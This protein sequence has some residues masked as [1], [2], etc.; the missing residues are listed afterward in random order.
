MQRRL[1]SAAPSSVSGAL[2]CTD[3]LGKGSGDPEQALVS[4]RVHT[5]ELPPLCPQVSPSSLPRNLN[6]QSFSLR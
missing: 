5:P 3:N 6:S 1:S 4:R 2:G